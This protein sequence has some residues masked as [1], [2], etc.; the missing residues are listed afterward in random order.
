MA[1]KYQ[2]T[3]HLRYREPVQKFHKKVRDSINDIKRHKALDEA[4][5]KEYDDI[6]NI[7][8]YGLL[9][10]GNWGGRKKTTEATK[11]K[12]RIKD[13]DSTF[14]EDRFI[15]YDDNIPTEFTGRLSG[16]NRADIIK[17]I[18]NSFIQ[19]VNSDYRKAIVDEILVNYNQ[20]TA[21][22][23]RK[24]NENIE[25]LKDFYETE[26]IKADRLI[27]SDVGIESISE[28]LNAVYQNI[29]NQ[30][31]HLSA[32]LDREIGVLETAKIENIALRAKYAKAKNKFEPKKKT[33]SKGKKI[34]FKDILSAIGGVVASV[35]APFG[36]AFKSIKDLFGF[37]GKSIR[38]FIDFLNEMSKQSA[39][40]V[41]LILS[42]VFIGVPIYRL[43]NHVFADLL[44]MT[45]VLMSFY[46]AIFAI[47]PFAASKHLY[48]FLEE[49]NKKK[50]GAFT[51]ALI[52]E[53]V[54]YLAAIVTY[55][56]LT[57][58]N[59]NILYVSDNEQ[60][61][62]IV[63]ILMGIVA[64]LIISLTVGFM[65]YYRMKAEARR[66]TLENAIAKNNRMM[67]EMLEAD[68]IIQEDVPVDGADTQG[69]PPA[70]ETTDTEKTQE[71][72]PVDD[73]T[74]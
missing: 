30:R 56:M 19:D 47:L 3:V 9:D 25:K 37:L 6:Y 64:P 2:N 13:D 12:S 24:L 17:T 32:E 14:G 50:R 54:V 68:V 16:Y 44:F 51:A 48:R 73:E 63:A 10:E 20:I 57:L 34:S 23:D 65:N 43:T 8:S 42:A 59:R 62:L 18:A 71:S 66:K 27:A 67:H 55:P 53:S 46:L 36:L 11:N 70:D 31:E 72:I 41:A 58:W 1:E 15:E 45:P 7:L 40:W 26:K 39:F 60:A 61:Q 4:N 74:I 28:K 38:T 69:N 52:F 21:D 33:K 35:F 22:N 5:G 49:E 29:E